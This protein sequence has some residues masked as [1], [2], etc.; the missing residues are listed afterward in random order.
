MLTLFLAHFLVECSTSS[1]LEFRVVLIESREALHYIIMLSTSARIVKTPLQ[2][3]LGASQTVGV[4]LLQLPRQSNQL[5]S[6]HSSTQIKRIFSQHPARARVEERMGVDRTPVPLDPP[7][8]AA[9]FEADL[10]P[11]GWSAP[12]GPNVELPEYPFKVPRT[13]NKPNDSVGFLPV[14]S[15][16]R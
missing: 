2:R 7:K 10:Y 11:N 12:P 4:S 8:F 15:K 9:V 16:F 3:C 6:K 1:S 13:K 14:Y 5:R